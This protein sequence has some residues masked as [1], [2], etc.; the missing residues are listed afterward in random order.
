[1]LNNMKQ[2]AL[3]WPSDFEDCAWQLESKGWFEGLEIVVDGR[4]LKPV[5]YDSVRLSQEIAD[6]ISRTGFFFEHFLIV[7]SKVTKELM[8]QAVADLAKTGGLD[9]IA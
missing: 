7:I 3:K 8:E 5:F 2:Y 6:E 9:R 4:T 1:M